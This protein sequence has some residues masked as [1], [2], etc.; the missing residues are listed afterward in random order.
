MTP[1]EIDERLDDLIDEWH[2]GLAPCVPLHEHLGM[3]PGQYAEWLP[4]GVLP[5][6]YV[7]PPH[8]IPAPG[9]AAR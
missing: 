7:L 4:R 2:A 6:G 9:E 5:E 1:D 8:A 3:T